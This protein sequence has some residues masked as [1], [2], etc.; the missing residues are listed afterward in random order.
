MNLQS[1]DANMY[2]II[3]RMQ[4]DDFNASADSEVHTICCQLELGRVE[5]IKK[6]ISSN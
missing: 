3:L 5:N 4:Y 1:F 6:Y 2:R